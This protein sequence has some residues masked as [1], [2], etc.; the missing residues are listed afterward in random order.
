MSD[1]TP[2]PTGPTIH[3]L[4]SEV[5]DSAFMRDLANII[6]FHSRENGSDT[7]DFILAEYLVGCLKAYD[8]AVRARDRWYVAELPA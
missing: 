8:A 2:F 4:I 5:Q 7:P 1:D 6:N 3:G